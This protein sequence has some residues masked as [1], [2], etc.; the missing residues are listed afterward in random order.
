MVDV[1]S[2]ISSDV[3]IEFYLNPLSGFCVHD[4]EIV[5]P[6]VVVIGVHH[7]R[8]GTDSRTHVI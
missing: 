4:D 2:G 6:F 7:D 8:I 5:A 3:V 1:L